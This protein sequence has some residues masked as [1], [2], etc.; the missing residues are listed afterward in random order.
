MKVFNTKVYGLEES[1]IR[2]GYPKATEVLD[3]QDCIETLDKTDPWWTHRN[4]NTN[5]K[6]ARTLGNAKQGSGHDCFLKG[7]LV[8]MDVEAP[9]YWWQQFQR[10]HFADIISSQS[11]MHKIVDMFDTNNKPYGVSDLI[12]NEFGFYVWKYKEGLVTM[13]EL[14]CNVPMGMEY[15]AGI[16]TNYL[17]LKTIYSQRKHHKLYMW[18]EVF[19]KWIEEL[20]MAR[21]LGVVD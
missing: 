18:N 7:I 8:Q 5:T 9:Q 11:K 16:T 21:E 13:D 1:I 10:Y 17:Q 6:R 15:V 4:D 2:S 19:C 14:L 20:P 12:W 3:I